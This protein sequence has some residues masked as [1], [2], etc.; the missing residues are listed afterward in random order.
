[1]EFYDMQIHVMV[2][3]ASIQNDSI[4]T[5]NSLM[6]P[7]N[8]HTLPLTPPPNPWHPRICSPSPEFYYFERLYK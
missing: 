4:T 8:S 2:T 7:L 6:L 3:T 5:G 1:M